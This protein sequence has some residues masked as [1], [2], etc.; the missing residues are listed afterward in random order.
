MGASEFRVG[1]DIGG[2][3]TDLVLIGPD[4]AVW[5][6]KVPS[7]PADYSAAVL[8]GLSQLTERAGV[9]PD[10][11]D[12]IVHGTTVATNA[13]LEKRGART[14]LITTA[15]FRDVLEIR[16][17]R[18]P[19]LYNIQ[20][21]K[22]A[23]LVPRYLRFEVPE[24]IDFRGE[25]LIPLDEASLDAIVAEI[26]RESAESVAICLLHS[27]VNPA[28]EAR[29]AEI[30]REL[31]PGVSL[32]V[33]SAITRELKEF[34]RTSTTVIDA[35]VKPVVERYL[36]S[37]H[38]RLRSAG[39]GARLLVMQSNGAVMSVEAARAQP[40]FIIES[41]PAAGV[42]A[43]QTLARRCAAPN[44]ITFDMGG[45]TAKAA[46][47]EQGE[48]GLT[49]EYEVGAGITTGTR[50]MKGDG[51]LLRIPAIDLAEV[52]AGGGSIAWVDSGGHLQVGPQS[53]GAEPGPA[54]Y[55]RGGTEP[56]ITDA[57]VVL[58]Y[59]APEPIDG[60]TMRIDAERAWAALAALGEPLR[61]SALEAA[62]AVHVIANA[63][64]SRPIRAVTVERGLDVRDFT[65]LA[66][67]GSG[68]IHA[69]QLARDLGIGRLL[70][71]PY[72]G[73][74]SALGLSQANAGHHLVQTYHRRL[75]ELRTDELRAF[76]ADLEQ[77]MHARLAELNYP[78]GA[79]RVLVAADLRYVGQAFNL[80]IDL[81]PDDE[82]DAIVERFGEQHA[83]AYGH[84]ADADPIEFVN[85][86]LRA[87]VDAGHEGW[88]PATAA[89]DTEAVARSRPMLFDR[90][91][92][93][94]DTPLISRADLRET[95]AGPLAIEEPDT[96]IIVP[97]GC[98]ASLDSW[99]N[100]EIEVGGEGAH[101]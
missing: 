46:L 7:T 10:A 29:I 8:D 77:T 9:R 52:G 5:S 43:G 79:L 25:V 15:G 28:H 61:L 21:E 75:D 72:A 35:Y 80:T 94:V 73:V 97:P 62:F 65:L 19:Q 44:L 36:A 1:V 70:V 12:E 16:R 17:V 55:G 93:L 2:T 57:N 31:L 56:T 54:C 22:P 86:R 41:G 47:I 6:L 89:S 20:W 82:L 39:F 14:A 48:A 85:L 23:P 13:I 90:A 45:T 96:T 81:V 30:L 63:R 87:I 37:L 98:R 4:G 69:A 38:D 42:I 92:G 50:L 74:F 68:P 40:C 78:A 51:Y 99:G 18:M 26:E 100:V 59:I 91:V 66:F 95:R 33:S 11:I 27:Y 67:G 76:V 3:F 24:R 53:A 83:R 32:S 60:S 49:D 101:D 64:M 34:E 58:G 84:R 71:P 88:P